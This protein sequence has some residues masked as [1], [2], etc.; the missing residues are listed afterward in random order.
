MGS[1]SPNGFFDVDGQLNEE[2][3]QKMK[4]E[5]CEHNKDREF[6]KKNCESF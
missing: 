2:H 6:A 4:K 1:S 5:W 3:Q